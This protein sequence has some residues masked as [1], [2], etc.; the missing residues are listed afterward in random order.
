[1]KIVIQKKA[2]L[3]PLPSSA[4]FPKENHADKQENLRQKH[5]LL[6]KKLPCSF[7]LMDLPILIELR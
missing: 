3:L 6:M 5:R 2:S 1:M 7:V 4:M